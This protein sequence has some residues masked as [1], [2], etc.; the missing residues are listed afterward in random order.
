[1]RATSLLSGCALS[2]GLAGLAEAAPSFKHI[3][4]IIQEN[5]TPDNLFGSNPSFE[6]G[7]NL[8]TYAYN[9]KGEKI[10]FTPVALANCYDINHTHASWEAAY[11]EGFDQSPANKAQKSAPFHRIR[12]SSS[13]TTRPERSSRISISRRTMAL[14]T[15]CSRRTRGR[16]IRLT[17]FCSGRRRRPQRTRRCSNRKTRI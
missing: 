10:Q 7:V 8:Q 1:M 9:S 3:V 2:L 14:P 17:N 12:N 16:A 11:T 5:R 13:S 15:T 6:P 4:V